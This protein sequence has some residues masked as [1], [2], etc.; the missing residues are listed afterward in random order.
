[1]ERNKVR[2]EKKVEKGLERNMIKSVRLLKR[3][4]I[5]KFV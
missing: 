3:S 1:M 4:V 2:L 5:Y